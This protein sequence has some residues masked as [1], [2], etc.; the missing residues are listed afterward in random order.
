MKAA[1]SRISQIRI[2]RYAVIG[3]ISTLIHLGVATAFIYYLSPS[4]FLSNVTGFLI[5]YLF[6][7]TMQSLHVFGHAI[8]WRKALRYF[9]TQFGSLLVSIALTHLF[10][11]NSYIKTF[12]VVLFM[13]MVTYTVHKFWT[14]K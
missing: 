4:V 13:P 7:Y 12:L 8:S 14:F 11:F 10:S 2:F 1:I 5:A 3:G 6:S 9:I